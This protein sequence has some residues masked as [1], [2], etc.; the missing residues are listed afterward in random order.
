M[1]LRGLRSEHSVCEDVDLIPSLTQWVKYLVLPQAA[2]LVT[3][4]AWIQFAVAVVSN[5]S[6]SSDSTLSL[7]TCI[8]CRYSPK[9]TNKQA[10]KNKKQRTPTSSSLGYTLCEEPSIK[11]NHDIPVN[12][13]DMD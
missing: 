2:V 6:C 8:C 9:K 5:L 12:L 7:G 3:D 11:A 13:T 10:N 1:W 4:V